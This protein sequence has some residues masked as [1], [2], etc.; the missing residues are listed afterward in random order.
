[1]KVLMILQRPCRC[2][3]ALCTRM[4]DEVRLWVR[5]ADSVLDAVNAQ[6]EAG[7]HV[8]LAFSARKVLTCV[9]ALM[10]MKSFPGAGWSMKLRGELG[11][12]RPDGFS[13]N[14]DFYLN[15]KADVNA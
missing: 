5:D 12:C 1:M 14:Y 10:D 4:S 2:D 3:D 15:P 13:M 11:D 8:I 9:G 6:N 7:N